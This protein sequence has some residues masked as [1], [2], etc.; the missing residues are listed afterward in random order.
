MPSGTYALRKEKLVENVAIR[1]FF[2]K[3]VS[4]ISFRKI[5]PLRVSFLRIKSTE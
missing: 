1:A 2:E 5:Y 4:R 3:N